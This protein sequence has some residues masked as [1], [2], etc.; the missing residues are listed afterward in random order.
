MKA[1]SLIVETSLKL[2]KAI[3]NSFFFLILNEKIKSFFLEIAN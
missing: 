1:I 2:I 3:N